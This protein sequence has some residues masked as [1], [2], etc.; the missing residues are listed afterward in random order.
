MYID[1]ETGAQ[2][3]HMKDLEMAGEPMTFVQGDGVFVTVD[4]VNLF[5]RQHAMMLKKDLQ[6]VNQALDNISHY[7]KYGTTLPPEMTG[8]RPKPL[9]NSSC[10]HLRSSAGE[11]FMSCVWFCLGLIIA[12]LANVMIRGGK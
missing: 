5:L 11:A 6:Q 9:P 8:Q 4:D 10:G 12:L 7:K 3:F 2:Q 1:K